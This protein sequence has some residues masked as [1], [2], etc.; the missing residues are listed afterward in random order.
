ME[1]VI[2]L[3]EEEQKLNREYESGQE[4][5]NV[6]EEAP[7]SPSEPSLV[8][9]KAPLVDTFRISAPEI[10]THFSFDEDLMRKNAYGV[11][12]SLLLQVKSGGQK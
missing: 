5:S 3:V 8:I 11:S 7:K 10:K 12:P 2:D 9:E 1:E 6:E 4:D